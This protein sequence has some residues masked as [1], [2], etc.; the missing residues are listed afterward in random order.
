MPSSRFSDPTYSDRIVHLDVDAVQIC[1]LDASGRTLRG[2]VTTR[3]SHEL[4]RQRLRSTCLLR[5]A[6]SIAS[7]ACATL[8]VMLRMTSRYRPHLP[9]KLMLLPN[10]MHPS[11]AFDVYKE[12]HTQLPHPLLNPSRCN[13]HYSAASHLCHDEQHR[14]P[15]NST[16]ISTSP[17]RQ[18]QQ[19][20][21]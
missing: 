3:F 13:L 17:Y 20:R 18:Q 10:V 5:L 11:A 14:R 16:S 15:W 8:M 9:M 4:T 12:G 19:V 2:R 21:R 1:V 7:A 6:T